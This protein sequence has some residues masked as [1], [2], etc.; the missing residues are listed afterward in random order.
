MQRKGGRASQNAATSEHS[1]DEEEA[2]RESQKCGDC[3]KIVSSSHK[4]LLCDGCSQWHHTSCEGVK[5]EIYDFLS[6]HDEKQ[7]IHWYCK[8]CALMHKKDVQC[9][10]EG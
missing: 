10:N 5:D 4:A 1:A 6:G 3:S 7:G 2:E 8:K 9:S